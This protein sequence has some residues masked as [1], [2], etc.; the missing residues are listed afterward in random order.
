MA[1]VVVD[2]SKSLASH[3]PYNWNRVIVPSF[4]FCYNITD[5]NVFGAW[6]PSPSPKPGS[7]RCQFKN[8]K[9]KG[10]VCQSLSE[11]QG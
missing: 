5:Q 7:S 6:I 10:Y 8:L 11:Y 1:P 4:H 2:V 9:A 3:Y